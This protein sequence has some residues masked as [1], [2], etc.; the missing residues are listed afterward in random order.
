LVS[1][2]LP[3]RSRDKV[4]IWSSSQSLTAMLERVDRAELPV[5]LGGEQPE[6]RCLVARAEPVPSEEVLF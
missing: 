2:L 4:S 1:P 5:F 6:E 3:Q